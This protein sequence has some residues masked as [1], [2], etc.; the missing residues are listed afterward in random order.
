[1]KIF[2]AIALLALPITVLAA[3]LKTKAA[4]KVAFFSIASGL[5]V[6]AIG[7]FIGRE[8]LTATTELL[9]GGIIFF[10]AMLSG[11]H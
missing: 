6:L 4:A 10:R 3:L 7:H 5:L 11:S 1:M 2:Y 8:Y 9:F